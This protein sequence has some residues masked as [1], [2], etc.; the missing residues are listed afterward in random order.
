MCN[1]FAEPPPPPRWAS[2]LQSL[3]HRGPCLANFPDIYETRL[4]GEFFI[5]FP[6]CAKHTFKSHY[7]RKNSKQAFPR[8]DLKIGARN[9]LVSTPS[10]ACR[11]AVPA[12]SGPWWTNR[13][14]WGSHLSLPLS[15]ES[16]THS[17][18]APQEP[19]CTTA[20]NKKEKKRLEKDS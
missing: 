7:A 4:G 1:L 14:L 10:E 6:I 19:G 20:L 15:W 2:P 12:F 5:F 3:G 8:R 13:S 16:K 9:I 17:I 18:K 11:A